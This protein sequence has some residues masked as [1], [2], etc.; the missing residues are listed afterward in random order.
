[1]ITSW[2]VKDTALWVCSC[3]LVG[4]CKK[5]DYQL[6]RVYAPLSP[7]RILSFNAVD[8]YPV[9]N[10]IPTHPPHRHQPSNT[11]S[12]LSF[13]LDRRAGPAPPAL[14]QLGP[15]IVFQPLPRLGQHGEQSLAH[16][17]CC[18]AVV[19]LG[20]AHLVD[21]VADALKHIVQ[22]VPELLGSGLEHCGVG[23]LGLVEDVLVRSVLRGHCAE[24]CFR[25]GVVET[26]A[27]DFGGGEG[28]GVDVL[29]SFGEVVSVVVCGRA[30]LDTSDVCYSGALSIYR[31]ETCLISFF[32]RLR[33]VSQILSIWVR[34]SLRFARKAT[35]A[36]ES[37]A[38]GSTIR[39][40]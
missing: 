3:L 24:Q 1:M 33:K 6:R 2:R 17:F 10:Q 9:S 14:G 26:L 35:M 15:D 40:Q 11:T 18:R 22:V 36:P 37:A 38:A 29:H 20:G 4:S 28:G 30:D 23:R 21:V 31:F 13:L 8:S 25:A 12:S 34:R 16:R 27:A 5:H 19:F 39:D 32:R 7:K